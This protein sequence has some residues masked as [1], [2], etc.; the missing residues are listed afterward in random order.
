M[1]QEC[2]F[3]F[4]HHAGVLAL[5]CNLE[6]AQLLTCSILSESS[7]I[8][9]SSSVPVDTTVFPRKPLKW[10]VMIRSGVEAVLHYRQQAG[11]ARQGHAQIM[12]EIP[13]APTDE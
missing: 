2:C 8:L 11:G 1:P 9:C 7:L 13:E 10:T 4:L 12:P 6:T 5:S 3:E